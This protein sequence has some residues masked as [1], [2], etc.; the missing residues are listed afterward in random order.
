MAIDFSKHTPANDSWFAKNV[1]LPKNTSA[2]SEIKEV[3]TGA[4]NASLVVYARV[5]GVTLTSGKKITLSVMTSADGSSWKT[6][7]TEEVTGTPDGE[8]L[9]YVLPPSCK[10]SV[11]VS[12]ATDD[13]AAAGKLDIYLGYIPR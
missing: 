1:D 3:G 8:I 4:Q 2:D 7:H 6:L 5:D 9:D 10:N 12:Y 11:K 13:T